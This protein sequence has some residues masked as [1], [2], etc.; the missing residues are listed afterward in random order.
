MCEVVSLTK[1]K[2]DKEASENSKRELDNIFNASDNV[3]DVLQE[4]FDEGLC[5]GILDGELQI[6][7]TV[8]DIDS[9]IMF[10]ESALDLVKNEY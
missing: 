1:Y 6:S 3:L 7:A 10:L 4:E 9:I 8:D 2:K 5:I